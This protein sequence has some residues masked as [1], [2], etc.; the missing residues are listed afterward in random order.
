M[1][2]VPNP[3]LEEMLD[4]MARAELEGVPEEESQ[5]INY[6]YVPSLVGDQMKFYN[7]TETNV[8]AHGE[9]YSGKTYVAAH[10]I[11]HHVWNHWNA[12]ALVVVGVRRQATGGGIWHKLSTEVLPDWTKNQP[13]FENKESKMDPATKDNFFWLKNKYGGWSQIQLISVPHGQ[14]LADRVKGMELSM[15]YVDELT[16]VD[17]STF[18]TDL[19][20]Q[21]GRRPHIPS[22]AQQY[23]AT[24]NPDGPSHWVYDEFFVKPRGEDG[25]WNKDYAVFHLSIKDNPDPKVGDYYRRLVN[26]TKGDPVKYARLIEG[27][28]IDTPSGESLFGHVFEDNVHVRGDM[29]AGTYLQPK[30]GIPITIGYDLGDVNHGI[31]FLQERV[32]HDKT[33]WVVFDEILY[34]D[35]E[36]PIEEL[37]PEIM[38]H[39]Q[40]WCEQQDYSFSFQHISDKAA[41]DRYRAA[42]GS[43]DHKQV[44]DVSKKLLETQKEKYKHLTKPIIMKPC[45]KPQGSV[46]ARIRQLRAML[47]N[48]EIF[49]SVWCERT[50]KAM[51]LLEGE[52]TDAFKPRRS[53][54]LH[55]YD[56]LS[57][58]L[59]F[60]A[61]GGSI[62]A[63]SPTGNEA[64]QVFQVGA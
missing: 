45:P 43:F 36:M 41:F 20:Q 40:F 26:S 21:L 19:S 8:L 58:A 10:K 60:N 57:Y 46:A 5:V 3:S 34:T 25:T 29:K 30:K 27:K 64:P 51:K 48:E 11:V 59:F 54:H 37:V 14:G 56:A 47:D 23:I 31:S 13:G 52:K 33:V 63:P 53:P 15:I 42:S 28:W 9:R 50:I 4:L 22:D 62:V 49:F 17:G 32:L 24:T 6:Q 18:F 1:N 61:C 38:D 7:A 35:T 55:I 44:Q 2:A 16:A 12:H 39:Q